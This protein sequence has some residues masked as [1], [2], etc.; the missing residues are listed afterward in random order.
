MQFAPKRHHTAATHGFTLIE[1]MVV[2]S[3]VGILTALALPSL[4]TF[5]G[6][7]QVA[8]AV[9]AFSASLQLAR[10]EAVKRGRFVRM[11]RSDNGTTCGAGN[12]LPSGWAS[13]W[14][15]YVDN[16]ASGGVTVADEVVRSQSALNN[17]DNITSSSATLRAFAFSPTGLMQYGAGSQGMNFSWDSGGTIRKALCIS[18][19]GRTRVVKDN[20]DCTGEY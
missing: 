19:T 13:G 12:N 7:W 8:N 10:S 3:I 20:T 14:I 16:D 5:I 18:F 15:V 11:C 9:N 6:N 17:F 4:R 1:M 2:L